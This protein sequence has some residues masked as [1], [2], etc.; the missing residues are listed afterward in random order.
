LA[1]VLEISEGIRIEVIGHGAGDFHLS[2]EAH[3]T[4]SGAT[5][6]DHSGTTTDRSHAV[7]VVRFSSKPGVPVEVLPDSLRGQ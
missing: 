2:I 3:D 7:Y 4:D 1:S 6:W 5:A